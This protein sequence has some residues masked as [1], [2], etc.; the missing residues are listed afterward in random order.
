M[1]AW[2]PKTRKHLNIYRH[3][4]GQNTK[5]RKY[6]NTKTQA[7]WRRAA[8]CPVLLSY[9]NTTVHTPDYIIY[10]NNVLQSPISPAW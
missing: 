3:P 1:W 8:Y 7:A 2:W 5:T 6:E 4:E 9:E 10:Y